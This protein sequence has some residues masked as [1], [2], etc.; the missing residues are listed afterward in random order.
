MEIWDLYDENRAPTG[1]THVRGEKIPEGRYHLVVHVWIRNRRGEYLVSRR[2]ANRPTYPLLWECVGGS[3]LAGESSLDAALR[4]TLE[5]VGIRLPAA[6]G[7][8]AYSLLRDRVGGVRYGDIMDAWLFSYE[9]DA[10]LARATT[11]E[12]AEA[13]WMTPARIRALEAEGRLVPSLSYFF[14]EIAGE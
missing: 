1:E 13:E 7:K 6:G 11:D 9:G 12:V 8:V 4:E 10:D 5:E 2:S 3:A 14:S